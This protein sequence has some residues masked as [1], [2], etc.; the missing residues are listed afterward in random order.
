[1]YGMPEISNISAENN[2]GKS[3]AGAFLLVYLPNFVEGITEED[4]IILKA[5]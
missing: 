3:K 2:A 5:K 4:F 1:M